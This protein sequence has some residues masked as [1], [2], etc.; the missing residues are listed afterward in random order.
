[1]SQKLPN[2]ILILTDQQRADTIGAWGATHMTTP[3]L[4]RL[5][6]EG[7]NFT[8]CHVTAPSCAPSRASLF[9]GMYPHNSGVFSNGEPW[10]PT[11]VQW[12]ADRGYHCVNI[13]KM[14]TMPYE[15]PG[16]FHHRFV[17]ENK[18]RPPRVLKDPETAYYDEWDKYLFNR[19]VEKPTRITYR[20]HPEYEDAL[21][22]Y[23]WPL[24]DD[25]HPDVFVGN[26]ALWWLKNRQTD[27]PLFLEI[28]FP[29]P[30][31]PFD[32]IERY[33][34][35]YMNKELPL[36]TVTEEELQNQPP[37]QHML[38]EEMIRHADNVGTAH[39]SLKWKHDPT[40]EQLHRMRAF[41]YAN[42]TMID[43]KIGEI[44]DV[45]REQGELD[46]T[47]II[48]ASDH[49]E[50][51]GDHGHIQKW[52]MYDCVTRVPLIIWNP[53]R[54]EGGK[55]VNSLTQLMDVAPTILELAGIE[56]P[57]DWDARSLL[58]LAQ[59]ETDTIREYVFAEQGR[60]HT[61][62][63]FTGAEL[64]TMVRSNEWKL[65]HYLGQSY[66]ELYDLVNDPDETR[67]L[68]NDSAF[69]EVKQS[70]LAV[71]REWRMNVK[72]P[73]EKVPGSHHV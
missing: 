50:A 22:A 38:R 6:R 17:V 15:T 29:G 36:P 52:T 2:I 44:I 7:V 65:V 33:T 69:E 49:G 28:G 26:M 24:D 53:S 20:S 47:V 10:S 32:P 67:N 54:F 25:L 35:L 27:A 34:Q 5:S 3:V 55:V 21:G 43:E 61:D 4:D 31:P 40:P 30:H 58:P 68:W 63:V 64:M 72:I 13:G 57:D 37:P 8:N 46:N 70:L 16:G 19:G 45:L 18:D 11:W 14:H 66:G 48:F 39:D 62:F 41:Y 59:G 23:E 1:M 71:L 42:V 51:L 9:T 60:D 12:L 73:G 56:V